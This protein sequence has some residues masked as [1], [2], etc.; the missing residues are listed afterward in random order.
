M[1]KSARSCPVVDGSVTSASKR[2]QPRT[3][4]DPSACETIGEPGALEDARRTRPLSKPP[5]GDTA[6]NEKT[7]H[8]QRALLMGDTGLEP[9]TSALSIRPAG[10]DRVP[11]YRAKMLFYE[12]NACQP[13]T[14]GARQTPSESAG[15]RTRG[16]R[17]ADGV[18]RASTRVRAIR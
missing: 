11:A 6:R 16:G 5:P 2:A 13:L 15:W 10:W 9:V 17:N 12:G 14:A 4:C 1:P 8:F 7:R 18:S 3:M